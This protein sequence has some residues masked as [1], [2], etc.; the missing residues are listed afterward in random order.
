MIHFVGIGGIGM[1]GIAEILLR[2]GYEISGT[3]IRR[4]DEVEKLHSLGA[5][6]FIGHRV[7]HLPTE[8]KTVVFSSAVSPN[9]PEMLEAKKRGLIILSRAEMLAELMRKK[10]SVVVSGSH[11]KTTTSAMVTT[12]MMHAGYDPTAVIGGKLKSISGNAKMGSGK[13]FV[14]ESDES[15]GSFLK[16]LPTVAVVTNVDREH[17]NHYGSY[18]K[19]EQAFV[20]FCQRVP[21]DG[22]VIICADDQGARNV[23]N[24]LDRKVVTYGFEAS[25]NVQAR[26]IQLL[27]AGAKY[28]LFLDGAAMGRIQLRVT[29][30]HNVYNSLAAVAVGIHVGL[31]VEKIVAGLAEYDGIGRRL[32][33]K[34]KTAN[35]TLVY[36][37]YA[38]HPSEIKASLQA[39]KIIAQKNNVHVL[40][41]PHRFSRMGDLWNEFVTAFNGVEN[42][43]VLPI[44]AAS[45]TQ[46]PGVTG[47]AFVKEVNA[48][49]TVACV[50]VAD[51]DRGVQELLKVAK[52]GDI[53]VSMGAG[54]VTRASLG[55]V[56]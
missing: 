36:D 18:S 55:L 16:L 25:A 53:V 23:T 46:I 21:F 10:P 44:Y 31:S 54:D 48:L 19:L 7:E 27:P 22:E 42:L 40:F 15:D 37:D 5:R 8:A 38:H 49:K 29:G 35:G 12:M 47:E 2:S 30:N 1:S 41:Q 26:N 52:A 33:F 11:G 39:L 6:I 34:G 45:E 20:E 3:D 56:A 13:W 50:H 32:E 24:L 14:A 4:N 28:E 9:N 17:L 51:I 43:F